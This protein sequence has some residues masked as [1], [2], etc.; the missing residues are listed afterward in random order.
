MVRR[1]GA[2][3]VAPPFFSLRS[4]ISTS[5]SFHS[6]N[7]FLT[8]AEGEVK[9]QDAVQMNFFQAINSALDLALSKNEKTVLFGEDVAFGGVFRCS[10]DLVKKYGSKRVFDSPLTE[11]GIVGFAIGMAAVGW[12]PI[13]EVQFADYIFPAF[14]QIVNEAA[15][16][17][18]RSGGQFHCGGLVI[19]SPCSAVAHGGMYHSQSVEGYFNHCPGIKIVMPSTPSD[20]KGL[21]LQCIEEEDPCIFFEPK[22]LYRAAVEYVDPTYYTIPLGKAR[23]VQEGEDVTVV[24]YGTQVGVAVKAAERARQDGISVAIIDLRTLKPWDRETVI[25]S[26]RKTGRVIVTHE[27]PKTGGLGSELVSSITQGCFLSLEAP[28]MRICGLDTPHPLHEQLYLP[29]ELKLY[30]AIKQVTAF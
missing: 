30:E 21:L 10:L 29:N 22:R 13:A 12:K 27:A 28:P 23:I 25:H 9:T 1:L 8:H 20:A 26:V 16:M 24:A 6:S 11:Q 3:C 4:S 19:R 14:D 17:R 15:K 18:F 2:M 7:H 5:K